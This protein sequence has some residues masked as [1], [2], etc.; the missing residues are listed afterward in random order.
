[1]DSKRSEKSQIFSID[2]NAGFDKIWRLP[3]QRE[4][5]EAIKQSKRGQSW[6]HK[7]TTPYENP[8]KYFMRIC[9]TSS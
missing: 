9:Q 4:E 7:T 8:D 6:R 2:N 3:K 5:Y 1:M